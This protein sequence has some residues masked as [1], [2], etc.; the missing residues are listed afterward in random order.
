MGVIGSHRPRIIAIQSEENSLVVDA[1]VE[2]L[3][4]SIATN[5][6]QTLATG[7]FV[8]ATT[9]PNSMKCLANAQDNCCLIFPKRL[10]RLT[11]GEHK[12][13]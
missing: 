7:L 1:F 3:E 4:D 2:G 6:G 12:G 5:G 13:A 11:H 8:Q 9:S 10:W